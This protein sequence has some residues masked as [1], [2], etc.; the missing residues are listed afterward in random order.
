MFKRGVDTWIS[1][2]KT[3]RILQTFSVPKTPRQV[4]RE[5]HISKLK[6]KHFVEKG[7]LKSLNPNARKGKLYT[8]TDKSRKKLGFSLNKNL[9][10]VRKIYG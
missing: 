5:L 8:L 4:E 9:R 7:L 10:L 6:L 2:P 3:R 1:K